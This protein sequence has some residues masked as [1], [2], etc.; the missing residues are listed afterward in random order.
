LFKIILLSVLENKPLASIIFGD[1]FENN[2][3]NKSIRD[4]IENIVL[5]EKN[6]YANLQSI[7]GK[8]G[9]SRINPET[10]E[11]TVLE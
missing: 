10:G 4:E 7:I 2:T 5:K 6:K 9:K 1:L 11:I 3:L 8:Y